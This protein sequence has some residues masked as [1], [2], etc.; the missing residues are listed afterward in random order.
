VFG[1]LDLGLVEERGDPWAEQLGSISGRTKAI[2]ATMI[3]QVEAEYASNY[4]TSLFKNASRCAALV[5]LVRQDREASA[6]S[7]T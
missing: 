7:A 6:A 1:E 5:E 3:E 4:I 2:L